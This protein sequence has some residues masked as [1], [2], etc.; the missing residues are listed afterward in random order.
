MSQQRKVVQ[1]RY[2]GENDTLGRNWP[3]GISAQALQ[4]GTAFSKYA[5]IYQ[6]GIQTNPGLKVYINDG[7][8]PVIIG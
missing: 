2:Y 1:I 3:K 6:I 4:N 7:T 5:P 8:L